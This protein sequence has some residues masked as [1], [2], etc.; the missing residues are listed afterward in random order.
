MEPPQLQTPVPLPSFVINAHVL[1]RSLSS[2]VLSVAFW[3][4]V[5]VKKPEVW[6]C[7]AHAVS[8]AAGAG[9]DGL[10]PGYPVED[11]SLITPVG[12]AT[13]VRVLFRR[14]VPS[15]VS[16]ALGV[17]PQ[18]QHSAICWSGANT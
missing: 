16:S 18:P 5:S 12:R 3:N 4:G 2:S 7:V 6:V 10:Q 8:P 14:L 15:R 11:T 1:P 9:F 13:P 17:S